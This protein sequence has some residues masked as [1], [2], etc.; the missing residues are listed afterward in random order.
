MPL[1]LPH[2][3]N[4][5]ILLLR[6]ICLALW[7]RPDF[8]TQMSHYPGISVPEITKLSLLYKIFDRLVTWP[9]NQI[10]DRFSAVILQE[11][12]GTDV[13]KQLT[14]INTL[15]FD[16][17]LT[18]MHL[19]NELIKRW[20]AIQYIKLGK[21]DHSYRYYL[22]VSRL[23]QCVIEKIPS[24]Y[25]TQILECLAT[26]IDA[27]DTICEFMDQQLNPAA[28]D[29]ASRHLNQEDGLIK[30]ANAMAKA[31]IAMSFVEFLTYEL[32]S[33]SLERFVSQLDSERR[34]VLAIDFPAYMRVDK[35]QSSLLAIMLYNNFWNQTIE[36]R[37]VII[38]NLLM[39][40]SSMHTQDSANQAFHEA[41]AYICG[42]LFTE[43][44]DEN[45]MS[46]AFLASYVEVS[47]EHFKPYLLAA[48]LTANKMTQGKHK[49]ITSTLPKLAEA[50]GAAGV[51]AGQA[52][53]SYP[54]TPHD[55]RQSLAH[56]KSQSRLPYRWDLWKLIKSSLSDDLLTSIRQVKN[57]LGGA[58]FYVAVEVEMNDGKTAVLRLMRENAKDEAHY[59]FAH[60]RATVEHCQHH[61]IRKINQDLVHI[62]NE[63][64]AG[65]KIEIDPLSVARQYAIAATIYHQPPQTVKIKDREYHV[66]IQPVQL[67]AQGPAC[68]LISKAEGIEFNDLKADPHN[69]EL[70]Q[71][72]ALAVCTS[73]LRN[74]LGDG[75]CDS[76]RHGAQSRISY[77]ETAKGIF[78][79]IVTH[80]DFGE[81]SPTPA[82]PAQLKHCHYFMNHAADTLF[83]KWY[84][85]KLASTGT[86]NVSLMAKLAEDMLQY[87]NEQSLTN[88]TT[89]LHDEPLD[90]LARLRRL[91]KGLLALND[92]F[93]V[94]ATNKSLVLEL[95]QV[96]D[97]NIQK[98]SARTSSSGF[99]ATV[100]SWFKSPEASSCKRTRTG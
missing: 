96:F 6:D 26:A 78:H 52:A 77:H 89:G 59:G 2:L 19:A 92:Y 79:V 40:G 20:G 66:T 14:A 15:L 50:M 55:I 22:T 27:Q 93:E 21:D 43:P 49:N 58:S 25:H 97:E 57:I 30:A 45:E 47:N 51:K 18:D 100:A 39:P 17:P 69:Q 5:T 94:L 65:A 63:A 9:D 12:P 10:R 91:F 84:L 56:L 81:I 8:A 48:V 85:L 98:S 28:D 71:A 24:L 13:D 54:G 11:L 88:S 80:Y 76:D 42:A 70:C 82:T 4:K 29:A 99:F 86:L 53:H 95:K 83:S 38:N 44:N 35:S 16:T 74:M 87:I 90:D 36:K 3:E 33:D 7:R 72:V 60:L 46:K 75:Y 23:T 41:F 67:F 64:E 31:N 37:A 61:G 68:Q 62:I 34:R 73:E 32:S 1:N